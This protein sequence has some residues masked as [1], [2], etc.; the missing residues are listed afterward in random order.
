MTRT[1]A[2]TIRPP[3]ERRLDPAMLEAIGVV[4]LGS[5]EYQATSYYLPLV[6]C[7]GTF[8][9]PELAAVVAP[10]LIGYPIVSREG[11]WRPTYHPIA[12]RALLLGFSLRRVPSGS[13]TVKLVGRGLS[14]TDGDDNGPPMPE[15]LIVLAQQMHTSAQSL[16]PALDRLRLAG[17]LVPLS[18]E[19]GAGRLNEYLTIDSNRY[20]ELTANE[21]AALG[22]ESFLALDLAGAMLQSRRRLAHDLRRA[23]EDGTLSFL[24]T[25]LT[26]AEDAGSTSLPMLD[27]VDVFVD[28][29]DTFG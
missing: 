15:P 25:T 22:R 28:D 21:L 13:S 29:S 27:A 23:D 7:T 12:V 24:R 18:N 11:Q 20:D 19:K 14:K 8:A 17:L 2:A 5:A 9:M 10:S 26:P 4:P 3:S 16:V 1:T 6:V